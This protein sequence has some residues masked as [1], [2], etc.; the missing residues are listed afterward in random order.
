MRKEGKMALNRKQLSLIHVARAQCGISN[1]LVHDMIQ[2]WFAINSLKL[3]S[4]RQFDELM[5]H[6]KQLGFKSSATSVSDP[7]RQL[8]SKITA[9]CRAINAPLTYADGISR[10]MFGIDKFQ[11]CSP[12]QLRKI[13]AAL[14]YHQKRKRGHH[15]KK[16]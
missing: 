14:E 12:R 9:Q 11:W 5:N 7:R 2:Q 10:N 16:Q 15:A 13:V 1:E 3:L 8:V 6:F 4:Q